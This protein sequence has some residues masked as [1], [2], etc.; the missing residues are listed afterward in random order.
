[1]FLAL[2]LLDVVHARRV[3]ALRLRLGEAPQEPVA[4]RGRAAAM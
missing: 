3:L 1:M 4:L 2:V